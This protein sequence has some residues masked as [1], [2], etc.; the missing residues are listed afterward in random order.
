MNRRR[1]DLEAA[2]TFLQRDTQANRELL[3]ALRYA[4]VVELHLAQTRDEVRGVLVRGPG[5]LSGTADWV[6]LDA[7]DA[8]A[9]RQLW[10]ALEQP[11]RFTISIHRPWIAAQLQHEANL[12]PTGQGVLGYVLDQTTLRPYTTPGLRRLTPADLE[13]IARS[14]CGWS[15][16]YA[17]YLFNQGRQPWAIVR[18]GVI[19]C[20][21]SSGYPCVD[22]EEVVGVWTHPAWRGQGLARALVSAV[23]ADILTR[24]RYACYTTTYDNRASQAVARAVGFRPTFDAV[25]WRVPP[26]PDPQ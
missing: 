17:R 1:R 24:Y 8:A 10:S 15:R 18:D 6:R 2:T 7:L 19:V 11:E 3:L 9:V 26:G 20:R 4:S 25:S 23:A 12:Q 22:S 5:P 21:A 16:G 14:R 13:L